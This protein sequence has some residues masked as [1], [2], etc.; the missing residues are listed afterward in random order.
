MIELSSVLTLL[1]YLQ[2]L[3]GSGRV[4]VGGDKGFDIYTRVPEHMGDAARG[5]KPWAQR[6]QRH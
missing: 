4:T 1:T 6:R 3:P 5:A 2:E